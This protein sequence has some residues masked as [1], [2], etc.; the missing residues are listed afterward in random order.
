MEGKENSTSSRLKK[1]VTFK[2]VVILFITLLLMIPVMTISNLVRERTNLKF[3]IE[4]DVAKAY[5]QAQTIVPPVIKIPYTRVT[6]FDSG[7]TVTKDGLLTL[8]PNQLNLDG[9]IQ[10]DKRKRSI[11]E[12]IVYKSN[13][14]LKGQFIIP[15]LKKYEKDDYSFDMA[16]AY[17]AMGITDYNGI[18]NECYVNVNEKEYEFKPGMI[19]D[20]LMQNGFTTSAIDL[21]TLNEITFDLVLNLKGTKSLNFVSTAKKAKLKINSDW[22]SP[23]FVGTQLPTDFEINSDGF[24]AEWNTNQFNRIYPSYWFDSSYNFLDFKNTYGVDLIEPVD[25]Y[26]KNRRSSKYALL[27]IAM[28]FG[29]FFFFEIMYRKNIHPIQYTMVGFALTVF[30]LLLISFTEHIG[31]NFA[32]FVSSCAIIGLISAYTYYIVKSKKAIGILLLLMCGLFTYIFVILQLED[33]ALLVGSIGLFVI[34]S[35]VMFL[36]RNID[37]YNIGESYD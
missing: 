17:I 33:Y 13:L 9:K 2:I 12:I 21:N 4:N 3:Q 22:P 19:R 10:S 8:L 7:K 16:A 11:Y 5:G 27:I 24:N 1:S 14:S 6:T 34:L 28:T 23:S 30:Y 29:I 31:F 37:W 36:S 18:Y 35:T 26:G 32:Y 20:P 15:D 25:G